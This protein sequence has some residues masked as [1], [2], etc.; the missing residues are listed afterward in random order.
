MSVSA[1]PSRDAD[2]GSGHQQ[3]Q[4]SQQEQAGLLVHI[5][6]HQ[7]PL[8]HGSVLKE[9]I[10]S[11]KTRPSEEP[12]RS[13]G[14]HSSPQ[15]QDSL[16]DREPQSQEQ[17]SSLRHCRTLNVTPGQVSA[18]DR[19]GQPETGWDRTTNLAWRISCTTPQQPQVTG[20][21]FTEGTINHQVPLEQLGAQAASSKPVAWTKK[22]EYEDTIGPELSEGEE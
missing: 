16:E 11:F 22:Q 14:A 7:S 12:D 3:Q 6:C 18:N 1:S 9:V 15:Q 21:R 5:E 8:W 13:F 2:A 10:M 17:A 20:R 19:L 4:V